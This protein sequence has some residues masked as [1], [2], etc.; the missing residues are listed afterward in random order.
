ME[1]AEWKL[2]P[3]E[4]QH[5]TGKPAESH[6]SR[7]GSRITQRKRLQ[8]LELLPSPRTHTSEWSRLKPCR[9]PYSPCRHWSPTFAP[10]PDIG[11]PAGER[12][13]LRKVADSAVSYICMWRLSHYHC[14]YFKIWF[15]NMEKCKR[16]LLIAH[17]S[18]LCMSVFYSAI[19]KHSGAF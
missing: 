5:S 6:Q 16:R 4:R 18:T 13:V 9:R 15:C 12:E 2:P 7:Q 3:P 14:L 1:P 11:P 8:R 19:I 17:N 10:T